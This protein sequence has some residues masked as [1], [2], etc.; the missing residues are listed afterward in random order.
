M[1]ASDLSDVEVLHIV[2]AT[3]ARKGYWANTT[4]VAVCFP[5]VPSK[6]V[7]AK[8]SQLLKRDLIS[9]CDCGCRG[10]WELLQAGRELAGIAAA[11]R[12]NPE[13]HYAPRGESA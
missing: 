13:E 8:L 1:K 3:C 9:G 7:A 6:V 11:W 4:E 10:D 5:D 2:E 12:E